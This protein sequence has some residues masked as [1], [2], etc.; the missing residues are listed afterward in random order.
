LAKIT[1]YVARSDLISNRLEKVKN[2]PDRIGNKNL[3]LIH[4]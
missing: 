2:E 3:Q 4:N 1:I